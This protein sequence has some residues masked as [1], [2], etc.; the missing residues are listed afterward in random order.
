[1]DRR[2][3]DRTTAALA[4]AAALV[5]AACGSGDS[6]G[7]ED[8][9]A[10]LQCVSSV[11]QELIFDGGVGRGGI[12]ALS[13]P[14]TSR[15]GGP[16]LG[17]LDDETRVFGVVT[18]EGAYAV[19]QNVMWWH[20]IVNVTLDGQEIA[21]TTCPLT[22]STLGFSREAVDG[23]E[24][25]V[26]GLLFFNNQVMSPAGGDQASL[27]PQMVRGAA[28]GPDRGTDLTQVP[29]MD[30]RWGK[31]KQL[32]PD[33]RV[34]NSATEFD[35][36]YGRYPYGDYDRRDNEST[37]G[38]PLGQLDGRRP[39][40]ERVLGIPSGGFKGGGLALPFLELEEAAEASGG[41]A[42][43]RVAAGG[44]EHVV[45][46]DTDARGAVAF[47]P[48]AG[49]RSLTFKVR[50]GSFVDEQTGSTWRLDGLATSGPMEG[51]RLDVRAK[52]FVSFWF[53]W[54][55]FQ[56]ETRIWTAP[57]SG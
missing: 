19:P 2:S 6:T 16:N 51:S 35:R 27:W 52:P 34:V 3:F 40:K 56:P 15:P 36:D 7:P 10:R 53:A 38:F 21:I 31:W 33:S 29:V 13:S 20:E 14:S 57:E 25:I 48:E 22:G 39:P 26:S 24:L 55:F 41:K 23:Q 9:G 28:C 49:G 37:L 46:W 44:R 42:A 1:M 32:F 30:M 50:D 47:D 45:F 43:L 4:T 54:A 5:A 18:E 17:F 11:D 8:P 12:P